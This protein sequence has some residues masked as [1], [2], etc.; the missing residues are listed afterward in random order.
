MH[1]FLHEILVSEKCWN[2][3]PWVRTKSGIGPKELY[4][5]ENI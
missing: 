1:K 4:A 3:Y 5:V 2:L